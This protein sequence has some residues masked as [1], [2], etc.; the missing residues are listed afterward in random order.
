M[1]KQHSPL[2]HFILG[3]CTLSLMACGKGFNAASSAGDLASTT[4]GPTSV[5]DPNTGVPVSSAK[6]WTTVASDTNGTVNGGTNDGSLV[7]QIDKV[8]QSL[9]LY[10]PLPSIFLA[11]VTGIQIPEMPGASVE[12]VPQTDGSNALGVVIPL[13][14][15]IKGGD[16]ATYGKLPNGDAVPFIPA[17]EAHGFAI[18]FPQRPN[19]RLHIYVAVN[20]AAVFVETPDW[21]LPAE[22]AVLP[23]IGFP[24]RNSAKTQVN[25]YFA[26]VPNRGNFASGVYVAS[27]IPNKA[28]ALIDQML[29]F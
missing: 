16:F 12:M 28:A 22:F 13:K 23:T 10:I 18:D 26:V 17:G 9:V 4:P 21:K 24:V 20:A 11:S 8:R 5:V 6:A 27:R 19:Y 7:I 2:K 29:R 1:N 3:T 14:Y 25:G 15:V